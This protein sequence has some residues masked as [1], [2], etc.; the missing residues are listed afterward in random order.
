MATTDAVYT[1]LV[2]SEAFDVW[3]SLTVGVVVRLPG[4]SVDVWL[5][6][7]VGVV[8]GLPGVSE[9][10]VSQLEK[11]EACGAVMKLSAQIIGIAGSPGAPGIEQHV[12][13]FPTASHTL[14]LLTPPSQR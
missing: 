11:S 9:H 12:L 4:V 10:G 2:P 3:L 8:V 7:I 13:G 1:V 6:V 5:S 14:G